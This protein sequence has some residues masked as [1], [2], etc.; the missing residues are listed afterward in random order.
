MTHSGRSIAE[1]C[2]GVA[3]VFVPNICNAACPFCYVQ[4]SLSATAHASRSVLERAAKTAAALATMGFEEVRFTGGEPTTFRNLDAIITP[5]LDQGLGYRILTNGL[6]VN[7]Q[8]E[9]FRA[10]PPRRFTLSIHDTRDPS[11]VFNVPVDATSWAS[12]R[13]RLAEIAE[14]EATVVVW[15]HLSDVEAVH[16]TLE[17]LANDGVSH[18]KLI[19]ENSRQRTDAAA[20][21]KYARGLYAE[22]AEHFRSFRFT[23]VGQSGCRLREKGFPAV[24]LGRGTVYSCCVQVGDR[25]IPSGYAE[26]FR[27]DVAKVGPAIASVVERGRGGADVL[28]CS[29]SATFCPLGLTQ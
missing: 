28:P 26:E 2:N 19:L 14:V 18:I 15:K 9:F 17:D 22:W 10:A 29:A 5:F 3:F 4:P 16:H 1:H 20:F 24:D 23:D 21:A 11:S 7:A 12:N 8:I 13:R 25:R 27:S 6:D